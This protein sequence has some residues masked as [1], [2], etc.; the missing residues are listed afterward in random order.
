MKQL[1]YSK[2]SN[3]RNRAFA[4][5]TDIFR[6]QEGKR[7][8]RKT[9]VCDEGRKHIEKI[10]EMGEALKKLYAG[11]GISCNECHMKKDGLW[12][13]YLDASTLEEKLDLLIGKGKV[14]DAWR[15]FS[16][17]LTKIRDINSQTDFQ[18]TEKFQDV[19]GVSEL[20][21]NHKCSSV[22]DIDLVCGNIMIKEDAWII[23]DYEWTFDF[24]IPVGYV[25]YRTIHYYMETRK[26]RRILEQYQPYE[27]AGITEEERKIYREMEDHF[28]RYLT[29]EH[30]PMREMYGEISPG[31]YP[32]QH[33]VRKEEIRRSEERFQIFF[34]YGQGFEEKNSICYKMPGG[35][36]EIRQE[37][38]KGT[39]ELR[40]D[41]GDAPGICR[42]Y[43]LQYDIGEAKI[44][45]CSEGMEKYENGYLMN[46]FDPQLY[47]GNVP[48]HAKE[49]R[50]KIQI[51][52]VEAES[53]EI[54]TANFQLLKKKEEEYRQK[55]KHLLEENHLQRERICEMK[56]TEES[57]DRKI[58]EM[59]RKIREQEYLIMQ[60]RGTKVW[61]LYE[62]YRKTIERK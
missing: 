24:P 12:L 27:F 11:S 54:C 20:P 26:I 38:P 16:G 49:L 22:T 31:V 58:S 10:A 1:I 37:I 40:I 9:A 23:I 50:I 44:T 29:F 7:F 41:P 55:A 6:D 36:L 57:K 42:I 19:F 61:K 18:M 45:G 48:E 51:F 47:L 60:M 15:I 52:P 59:E 43:E 13:E 2:Y 56:K 39:R 46:C 28:Q 34:S 5:R 62:K 17:Y 53:V 8:V 25:L 33:L 35:Y 30:V 21:G 32:V 4:I 3:E 14:E